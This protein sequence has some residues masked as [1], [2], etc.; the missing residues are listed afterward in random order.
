MKN[1]KVFLATT[2]LEDFWDPSCYLIF[3]GNWCKRRSRKDFW[4]IFSSEVLPGYFKEE[5]AGQIY[6]YLNGVFERLVLVLH[7]QMNKVHGVNFSNRYWK[8]I[9]GSWLRCY[10]HAVYDRY[11]SLKHFIEIHPKFDSICLD[12]EC[13]VIPRDKI[14]FAILVKND[15][16]NLQIYSNILFWLGYNM[17]TKKMDIP[18]PD[19]SAYFSVKNRVSKK[20]L[21]NVYEFICGLFRQKNH[22]FLRDTYFSYLSLFKLI[23]KT[24]GI[25]YPCV[26]EYHNF[27]GSPIDREARKILGNFDFGENEFEK[28]LASFICFDMPKSM[29]ED[30]NFIRDKARS[31]FVF[32]PKAIMSATSWWFDEIFLAWAAESAEKKTMLL[33]VQHGGNYGMLELFN[34]EDIEFDIVDKYYSWGWEWEGVRVKVKPMPASKLI[35]K[36]VKRSNSSKQVLYLSNSYS[37]YLLAFPWSTKFWETCLFNQGLFLKNISEEIKR[38]LKIRLHREDLGWDMKERLADI[39][40]NVKFEGW[41]VLFTDSLNNSRIYVSDHPLHSTTFIEALRNNKPTIVFYRPEIAANKLRPEAAFYF[42][43]LKDNEIVFDDP[44]KAASHLNSVYSSALDWWNEPR[45]QDAVNKF[46]NKF[47]RTSSDWLGEWAQEISSI[48]KN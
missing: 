19:S 7:K 26:P 30:F 34:Q 20:I 17:P 5:D 25:A 37:R 38:N 6:S 27:S 36:K 44:V 9:S 10:I 40:P 28:M 39:V 23:L 45:R 16:Y 11:R 31:N 33:G 2:A 8:I 35:T 48:A 3:L 15:E 46:L 22:V 1:K 42:K 21:K 4:K 14:S 32:A 29:V 24:K 41:D 12:K 13:F 18:M 47:G 43:M